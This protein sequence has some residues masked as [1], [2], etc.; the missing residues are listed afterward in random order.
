[1][2]RTA[3]PR[4]KIDVLVDSE[5]WKDAGTAKAVVRRAL[6]QA[7]TVLSTKSA[8]LA[9]VLT[10]DA[11][12]RRLNRNWRGIDA[13]TNVLSFATKNPGDRHGFDRLHSPPVG[14]HNHLHYLGDI[15]LAYETVKREARRDGKT[16]DHHLTH[17]AVHGFL[18]LLGYDHGN[19]AQ[20]RRMETTERAILRDLAVPDPYGA[21]GSTAGNAGRR[22]ATRPRRGRAR[23]AQNA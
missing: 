21:T 18:H 7:A 5:H 3:A 4:L 12:M 8:G 14:N 15:V 2:K 1:M 20:A 9:I 6:K 22:A 23:A 13:P 19:D 17:L 11:A 10:D 16:F